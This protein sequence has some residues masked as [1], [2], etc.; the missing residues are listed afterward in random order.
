MKKSGKRFVGIFTALCVLAAFAFVSCAK[1]PDESSDGVSGGSLEASETGAPE[2]EL[3]RLAADGYEQEALAALVV[4]YMDRNARRVGTER[5]LTGVSFGQDGEGVGYD[6]SIDVP[7]DPVQDG[8]C[9]YPDSVE[10]VKNLYFY[11]LESVT[12]VGGFEFCVS[13]QTDTFLTRKCGTGELRVIVVS[14]D[15]EMVFLCV[16]GEKG[17]LF[18][19]DENY[20]GQHYLFSE[21]KKLANGMLIKDLSSYPV[22]QTAIERK[23]ADC[24][25]YTYDWI[26]SEGGKV[27]GEDSYCYDYEVKPDSY[28]QADAEQLFELSDY[29]SE[30]IF[31]RTTGEPTEVKDGDASAGYAFSAVYGIFDKN[32]DYFEAPS[33]I[34]ADLNVEWTGTR[35]DVLS[36]GSILKIYFSEMQDVY[37]N[38]GNYFRIK[39]EKISKEN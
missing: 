3:R 4:D 6:S 30:Y 1:T 9:F 22:G 26:A 7:D 25:L 20:D 39:A 18:S 15:S 27:V 31:V 13:V 2:N 8:S 32:G 14:T 19:A 34:Y 37:G 29:A 12:I 38:G 21:H 17:R 28:K 11:P 35:P 24:S 23:G 36:Q 5:T 16:E 33:A 10:T